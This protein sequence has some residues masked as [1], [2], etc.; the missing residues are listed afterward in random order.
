MSA[1]A[2]SPTAMDLCLDLRKIDCRVSLPPY[3]YRCDENREKL[4]CW[5]AE[6]KHPLV[7]SDMLL[8]STR[9]YPVLRSIGLSDK[10]NIFVSS[11]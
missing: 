1:K 10:V 11:S 6:H 3:L 4:G 8:E 5:P 2:P 7:M 9:L